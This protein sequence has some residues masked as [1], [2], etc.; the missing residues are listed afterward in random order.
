MFRYIYLYVHIYIYIYSHIY[1]NIYT[2]IYTYMYIYLYV[3]TYIYIY[4]EWHKGKGRQP[5]PR[6]LEVKGDCEIKQFYTKNAKLIWVCY[7]HMY[8]YIYGFF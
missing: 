1:I 7:I 4:I 3:Y 6:G 2:H 8:I 5:L